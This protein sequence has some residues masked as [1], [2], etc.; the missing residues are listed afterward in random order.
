MNNSLKI[1]ICS[2]AYFGYGLAVILKQIK[3]IGCKLIEFSF[4]EKYD[5]SFNQNFF[6]SENA[7]SINNLLYRY[8]VECFAMSSHMDLG[9]KDSFD[10]FKKRIEFAKKI[11]ASTIISNS[12]T[13]DKSLTFMDTIQ[14]LAY[15][16]EKKGIVISL[17]NPGDGSNNLIGTGEEGLEI[18]KKINSDFVKLN[19]DFLNIYTYSKG[20]NGLLKDL[21]Y[22]ID[23]SV[24]FHLKNIFKKDGL[25]YFTAI[26][27][28]IIKYS[29]ILKKI[30]LRKNC[31]SIGLELPLRFY[32]N[33][34]F[35]LIYSPLLPLPKVSEINNT[36]QSSMDYILSCFK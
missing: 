14:K 30:Y 22:A 8:N 3:E 16:A 35:D 33:N 36:L 7:K 31:I 19:Y 9:F 27:D 15:F 12:S 6:T 17:E 34:R 28:N 32:Y 24:H 21:D 26:N 13:K 10:I 29:E 1:S 25:Y 4:I 23:Q 20:N 5:N 2:I 11:G 18:V